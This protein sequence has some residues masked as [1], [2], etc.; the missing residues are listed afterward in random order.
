MMGIGV[1]GWDRLINLRISTLVMYCVIVISLP[2]AD[3]K[4]LLSLAASLRW[5]FSIGSMR[6]V[7]NSEAAGCVLINYLMLII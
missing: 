4:S 3:V 1:G 6:D 2:H 7:V 5:F